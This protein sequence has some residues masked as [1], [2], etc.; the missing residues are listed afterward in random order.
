MKSVL[1]YL[2]NVQT[3]LITY[4]DPF[5]NNRTDVIICISGNP[6]V[7][8]FYI[9]FASYLHTN[10]GLPVCVIG[11]FGFFNALTIK[12]AHDTACVKWVLELYWYW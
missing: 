5:Q 2:N 11:N 9:E 8:D 1:V 10:T 3:H 7:P 6:G 4:G 12:P